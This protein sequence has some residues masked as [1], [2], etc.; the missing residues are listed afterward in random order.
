[1]DTKRLAV[2]LSVC[3]LAMAWAGEAAWAVP[4]YLTG[5]WYDTDKY[6]D[7]GPDESGSRR[8]WWFYEDSDEDGVWNVD[9]GRTKH[10]TDVAGWTGGDI[11]ARRREPPGRGGPRPQAP[12]GATPPTT[13]AGWA[14]ET[15]CINI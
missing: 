9:D 15:T 2:G 6:T 11:D 1:M 4:V 8:G 3:A 12:S 5:E 10:M 13:R 14:P 7:L